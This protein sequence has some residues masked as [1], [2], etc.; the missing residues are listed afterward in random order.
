MPSLAD[1][2]GIGN[3]WREGIVG[4]VAGFNIADAL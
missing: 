2:N 1:E 4:Y 3:R